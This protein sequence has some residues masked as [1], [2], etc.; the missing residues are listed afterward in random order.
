MHTP[1]QIIVELN[2]YETLYIK[3]KQKDQ[4]QKNNPISWWKKD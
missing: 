2:G 1:S 3:Y 4:L